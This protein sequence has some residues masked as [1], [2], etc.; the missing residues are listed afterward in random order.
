MLAVSPRGSS[1]AFKGP[2]G[3]ATFTAY[4]RI[5]A[6]DL[7]YLRLFGKPKKFKPGEQPVLDPPKV[8][9]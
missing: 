7:H 5:I 8:S 3:F 6:L 4:G 1:Q 9:I 2:D